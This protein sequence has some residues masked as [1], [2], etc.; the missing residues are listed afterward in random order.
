[1]NPGPPRNDAAPR[2]GIVGCGFI[3]SIHARNLRELDHARVTMVCDLDAS[4]A[5]GLADQVNATP[6]DDLTEALH[7]ETLDALIIATPPRV[8]KEILRALV[9][10]EA[11]L[12]LYVEKPPAMD[13]EEARACYRAL[14]EG[15]HSAV[16]GFGFRIHPLVQKARALLRDREVLLLRTEF[17]RDFRMEQ[18]RSSEKEAS[19][20]TEE[21]SPGIFLDG[22]IH[23]IDLSRPLGGEVSR[24]V[25]S[26]GRLVLAPETPP[27]GINDT[28]SVL[29]RFRSGGQAVHQLAMWARD[30]RLR[31]NV[32]GEDFRLALDFLDHRLVGSI[33]GE[34]IE[35]SLDSF[36]LQKECMRAFT[37]EVRDASRTS[38]LPDYRDA[39]QSLAVA[40]AGNRSIDTETWEDVR[41]IL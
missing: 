35:E 23:M 40:L 14:R 7:A 30:P 27:K 26:A 4:K 28:M 25:A 16:V 1:M 17:A 9:S 19:H 3:G 37:T 5:S 32:T 21:Q 31:M 33:D 12:H 18:S 10:H 34:T 29:T 24:I 6:Y 8:R 36:P 39:L 20:Y 38:N 13:R 15:S 22:L 41:P 11:S 2:I